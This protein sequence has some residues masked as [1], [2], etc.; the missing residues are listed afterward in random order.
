MTS[1]T[2]ISAGKLRTI[3]LLLN[4]KHRLES[5]S[6]LIEGRRFV[7]EALARPGTVE[8]LLL[9]HDAAG[10]AEGAGLL[11]E[12]SR[13]GVAVHSLTAKQLGAVSD[14]VTSQGIL[15]VIRLPAVTLEQIAGREGRTGLLVA[16][17]GVSDPGNV[18]TIIRTCAWFGA[19]GVLL[20]GQSVEL[21]NP[22]LLR[23][24]MGAVF[25]IP[26]AAGVDLASAIPFLRGRGFD[27][28]GAEA[29]GRPAREALAPRGKRLLVFGSEAH[30]LSA[31]VRALA[32]SLF[33]IPGSGAIE[34]L[35]VSVAVGIALDIV[36]SAADA[37]RP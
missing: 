8:T 1:P 10:T 37:R 4:K 17:D 5:G 28:M 22:K 20:S 12:A 23:A 21:S 25:A 26:V 11:R 3:R 35:N 34:S 13:N 14:T 7:S 31:G 19:D 29:G 16:L 9:S 30:G 36:R 27:V 24:T 18:G 32:D 6:C 2:P 33:G 15:A